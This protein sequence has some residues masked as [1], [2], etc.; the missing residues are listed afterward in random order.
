MLKLDA[1]RARVVVGP[2]AALVSRTVLL[3]DVNW[4]ADAEAAFDC[5]VK[6][7]SMRPP[8]AARVTPLA[9]RAARVELAMAEYAIAPGQACVFYREGRVLGGGWI[10]SAE[11]I[12]TAAE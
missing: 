1:A 2:R 7:R 12:Q 10:A 5:A 3:R 4:L 9:G 6:V 11:A 8:A